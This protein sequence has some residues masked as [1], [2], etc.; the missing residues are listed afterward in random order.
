MILKDTALDL[1]VYKFYKRRAGT[2]I[3][4]DIVDDYKNAE[5]RLEKIQSGKINLDI[6]KSEKENLSISSAGQGHYWSGRQNYI[7]T[8]LYFIKNKHCRIK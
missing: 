7:N 2:E 1:A 5:K 8:F 4:A 3:P 6:P